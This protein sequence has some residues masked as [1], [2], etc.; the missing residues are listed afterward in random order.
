MPDASSVRQ[1]NTSPKPTAV[2]PRAVSWAKRPLCAMTTCCM[3]FRKNPT[4][5]P[6]AY[7]PTSSGITCCQ[8]SDAMGTGRKPH[9]SV[10]DSFV[11]SAFA[12]HTPTA[13]RRT[14]SQRSG[15]RINRYP[16]WPIR[17]EGGGLQQP[18][19]LVLQSRLLGHGAERVD[20]P[21][22]VDEI[23]AGLAEIVG[24]LLDPRAELARGEPAARVPL[25]QSGDPRR[26]RGRGARAGREDVEGPRRAIR[27]FQALPAARTQHQ[28][29]HVD[30]RRR[31]GEEVPAWG[32]HR[33]PGAPEVAVEG[34]LVE[35]DLPEWPS[36]TDGE[37]RT[38]LRGRRDEVA[39]GIEVRAVVARC[40]NDEHA[41]GYC[42]VHRLGE[43]PVELPS[44]RSVLRKVRTEAQVD[45]VGAH[46]RRVQDPSDDG[47][48][49]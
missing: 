46:V 2:S 34:E 27:Y 3:K 45:D 7:F 4:G 14:A 1:P 12:N 20:P 5:F 16:P 40:R 19:A 18:A 22:A 42:V 8:R 13:I 17:H 41:V 36:G 31:A 26:M 35:V 32:R 9:S 11:N 25:D 10:T 48:E 28:V 43:R 24:R 37:R 49:R 44:P 39:I 33:G 38:A 47:A 6:S 30:D 29:P 23:D 21:V 15:A